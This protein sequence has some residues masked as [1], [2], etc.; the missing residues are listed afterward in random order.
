[1]KIAKEQG[2]GASSFYSS[3]HM[4]K[5][6]ELVI[7][8]PFNRN[9]KRVIFTTL[10]FRGRKAAGLVYRLKEYMNTDEGL[11]FPPKIT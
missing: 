1:M 10:R 6:N 2:I 7:D 11:V 4:L 3:L 5:D 8:I 9:G